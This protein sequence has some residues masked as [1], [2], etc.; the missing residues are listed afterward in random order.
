[1]ICVLLFARLK[2]K[3]ADTLNSL[4]L[5]VTLLCFNPYAV[6]DPSAVLSV[7][8]VL[9]MLV[10]KPKIDE[11]IK[12]EK[13]NKFGCYI[14]DGLTITL[15]VMVTTF[16]AI[17]LFFS[18]TTFISYLANLLLIPLAQ[19]TMIGTLGI[20]LFGFI[21]Y[22][23]I[24]LS[25][26]TYIPAKTMLLITEFL[27]KRL[28]FLTFDI[29]HN[30]FIVSYAVFLIF[31]G[32]SLLIKNNVKFKPTCALV[33]SLIVISSAVS[34]YESSVNTYLDISSTNAVVIY[35]NSAAIV[36]DADN[37]SD[38]YKVKQCLSRSKSES[39]LFVNCNYDNEKLSSLA[40]NDKEF[41]NNYDFDIDLCE[42]VNVK[43]QSG[44]IFANVNN[45]QIEINKKYVI[46]NKNLCYQRKTKYI[47]DN[48]D[49]T[50]ISIRK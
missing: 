8:S 44:V 30:V 28:Y 6:T 13:L 45:A 42:Q 15:S 9:G 7:L 4:G 48:N 29:S 36:V 3:K 20:A 31:I 32:V 40:K 41:L 22:F 49:D 39:V 21:K 35:N 17:W 12:P 34:V 26:L 47:Y 33:F 18:N 25:F 11:N 2:N 46:I 24:A 5:A 23:G 16:P 10:V 38:Y 27:S 43:Y 37:I 19:L 1:M 14:Y 50:I